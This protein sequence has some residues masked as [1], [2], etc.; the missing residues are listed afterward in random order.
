MEVNPTMLATGARGARYDTNAPSNAYIYHLRSTPLPSGTS[1]IQNRV[2]QM[3]R[4][5]MND[6]AMRCLSWPTD[7]LFN[8]RGGYVGYA[9][10]KLP[11]GVTLR[12]AIFE[13]NLG[14]SQR[15]AIAK[16]IC[17]AVEHAHRNGFV[18]GN[19]SLD[20]ILVDPASC[21]AMLV[22]VPHFQLS[23]TA[24]PPLFCD[25]TVAEFLAPEL[26]LQSLNRR[27]TDGTPT[28]MTERTDSF[29][30]AVVLFALFSNGAHPYDFRMRGRRSVQ[31]LRNR[32]APSSTPR[33]VEA[34]VAPLPEFSIRDR[35]FPYPR[36]E[37][38]RLY[39]PPRLASL[40]KRTFAEARHPRG[41][42]PSPAQW[43]DALNTAEASPRGRTARAIA[44]MPRAM[45]ASTVQGTNDGFRQRIA[46]LYANGQAAPRSYS[47][48]E[49][50][51]KVT[52]LFTFTS[53]V[54]LLLSR[55]DLFG[56]MRIG[57]LPQ[58]SAAGALSLTC[59][60]A[61]V[62]AAGLI[63][64]RTTARLGFKMRHYVETCALGALCASIPPVALYS[65]GAM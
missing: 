37:R 28:Y 58:G 17:I 16:N 53:V 48:P 26:Q 8:K 45:S 27:R 13:W 22:R 43:L 23:T 21:R 60:I 33:R 15:V 61:G 4:L 2:E 64:R 47:Q 49:V 20:S 57:F 51:W 3:M 52:L 62:V 63:A 55:P 35:T 30:L 42:R 11:D 34:M 18:C 39:A 1:P 54:F 9:S 41:T 24:D 7:T 56:A 10:T 14:Y 65:M 19:L 50:F 12:R 29:A 6:V 32:I 38:A 25:E 31:S 5:P 44:R 46:G 36:Y 59:S 40:L